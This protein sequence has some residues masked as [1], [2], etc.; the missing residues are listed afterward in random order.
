MAVCTHQPPR[1]EPSKRAAIFVVVVILHLLLLYWMALMRG[2]SPAQPS[3]L[4]IMDIQL[5]RSGGS[6][7]EAE[8]EPRARLDAPSAPSS[9]HTPDETLPWP[10]TPPAPP[11]PSPQALLIGAGDSPAPLTTAQPTEAAAADG[12][13]TG[14]LHGAGAG[15]GSGDGVGSGSGRGGATGA[16]LIRAPRG[17]TISRNISPDALAALPGSWAVLRCQIR[18]TGRLDSCRVLAEQPAGSGVRQR[19]LDHAS[20]FRFRPPTRVGRARDRTRI[21]VAIAFPPE[22]VEANAQ[23]DVDGN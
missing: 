3:F 1:L 19:A 7:A 16:V 15:S 4:P 5:F 8:A 2:A 11:E 12:G 23:P 18:L 6:G 22:S 21:T 20:E 10:D 14:G 13:G 17:A 9:I